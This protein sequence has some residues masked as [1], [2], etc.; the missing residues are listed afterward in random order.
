MT[1]TAALSS[2]GSGTRHWPRSVV[3]GS[4]GVSASWGHQRGAW[5]GALLL[6]RLSALDDLSGG[7]VPARL[8]LGDMLGPADMTLLSAVA[9]GWPAL[10]AHF[11]DQLLTRLSGDSLV[12]HDNGMTWNYLALVA[13]RQQLLSQELAQAVADQ[14]TL[15]DNDGVLAWY[16]STHRGD[17]NLTDILI[18]RLD[19]GT[20][21]RALASMLLADPRDLGLAPDAVQERLRSLFRTDRLWYP[22]FQS[23]ALEALSD[24]FPDN[25]LVRKFW[26]MIADARKRGEPAG[27]HPRTY[28]PLAYAAVPAE[29]LLD[30]LARDTERMAAWGD[31]YFDTHFSR[32]VTRRL[33][34]DASARAKIEAYILASETADASAACFASLTAAAF[35]LSDGLTGNLTTRLQQQLLLPAPDMTH[36]Y[37]S[38]ADI[39]VPVLLLQI[40]HSGI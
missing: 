40:L 9:D 15:L 21:A 35:S 13:D 26:D 7:Q 32:A 38:G 3:R 10:R 25:D 2:P 24:G 11:G 30:L 1:T 23:G 27:M 20:N 33:R 14:P 17:E 37:V 4:S 8:N 6:D 29:E 31:T 18:S 19:D 16:A 28:Y 22:P 34:S 5:T 39:P 36:D 12:N